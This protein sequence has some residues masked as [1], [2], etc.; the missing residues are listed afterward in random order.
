MRFGIST[1]LYSR[2]RLRRE[3]L[4]E[5]KSH[6]FAAIELFALR[7]HFDYQDAA[8]IA[9]LKDWLGETGLALHSIHA[10]IFDALKP[11]EPRRMFS[12]AHRHE[13]ERSLT[14]REIQLALGVAREIH[15]RYL[16]LHL[17]VPS[18]YAD[19]HDNDMGAALKCLEAVDAAAAAIGVRVA[20][21]VIPNTL[22][23][24]TKLVDV[25]EED[26]E[27]PNV[28]I[29]L[30][31][32]HAH[33]MGDLVDAIDTVSGHLV[34]THVHDN[35]GRKDDHLVPYEGT[36]D[37]PSALMSIQKVGYDEMLMFELAGSDT[38]GRSLAATARA[39]DRFE[40]IL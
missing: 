33:M 40:K 1:H 4:V 2:E 23:A 11:G 18:D 15:T 12:T 26:V 19:A 39:R 28:G 35:N 5:I 29:C 9:A 6:G 14:I 25:L 37:W 16:V 24:A 34:T 3:H 7:G 22:S 17:G 13:A 20:A 21:E 10:P 38:P 32:G 27:L 31:F 30:D 36:I 8:A